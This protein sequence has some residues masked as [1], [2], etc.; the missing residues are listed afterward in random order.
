MKIE[1]IWDT[2]G[3]LFASFDGGRAEI[4]WLSPPKLG[5]EYEY[6]IW[7]GEGSGAGGSAVTEEDAIAECE[8]VIAE[9][10]KKTSATRPL[11]PT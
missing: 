2:S 6:L 3:T 4:S 11:T 5:H 1:W 9:H 7:W 10:L 8:R